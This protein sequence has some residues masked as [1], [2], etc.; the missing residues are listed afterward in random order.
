MQKETVTI[1]DIARMA[2]VS[3]ST[4]SRVLRGTTKVSEEKRTAVLEAVATLDYKPNVFARS[5]ASGQSMTIGVITQNF[6][7]PFYDSILSGILQGLE[8]SGYSPIFVDGRWEQPVEHI[9]LQTLLDRRVDGL[10]L[11]G[12]QL[13]ERKIQEINSN[14]PVVV[15]ARELQSMRNHCIYVNNFKAAYEAV[16][17]LLDLGHR[18]IAHIA[19]KMH[20]QESVSDLRQRYDGY[21]QALIDSGIQPDPQLVIEGDLRQQSG[22]LAV[23]MLLEQR[24][25]FSAIFAANDQMAFGARLALYRRGIR[26]PEDVSLVGFDDQVTAAYMVPPLTTVRQPSTELGLAAAEAILDLLNDQSVAAKV[27]EGQLIVRE[28]VQ[29]PR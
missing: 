4:V 29:R 6:G 7:S 13:P 14:T 12:G 2:D 17:Y 28:S 21:R 19:A 20:Y 22:V 5:L 15:V 23:N 25:P 27:F 3:I 9:A 11:V 16:Q 24:R 26:V 1:T 18:S 8:E 10:I